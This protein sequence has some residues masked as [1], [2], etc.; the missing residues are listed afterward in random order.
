[1]TDIAFEWMV[2][3]LFFI[4]FEIVYKF[5]FSRELCIGTLFCQYFEI[6]LIM[7]L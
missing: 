4:R 6:K 5:V 3:P 7:S 2:F 1:M